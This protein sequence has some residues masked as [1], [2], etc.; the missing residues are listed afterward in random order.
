MVGGWLGLS[1][2]KNCQVMIEAGKYKV[3]G[4]GVGVGLLI[5]GLLITQE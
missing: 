2:Q 5:A 3:T 1:S 4:E